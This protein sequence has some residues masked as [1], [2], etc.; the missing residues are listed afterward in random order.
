MNPRVLRMQQPTRQMSINF[1]LK[2]LYD[3]PAVFV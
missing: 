3:Y 2:R 1:G